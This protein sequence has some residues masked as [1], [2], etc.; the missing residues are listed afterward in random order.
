MKPK[1]NFRL[2][3]VILVLVIL[4]GFLVYENYTL[5][6]ED[7]KDDILNRLSKF[8][9]VKPYVDY[10]ASVTKLTQ[11]EINELAKKQPAIY[12]NLSGTELYKVQYSSET[13]GLLVIFDAKMNKIER[14]FRV[15]SMQLG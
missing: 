2:Y 3:L 14:I 4:I 11:S 6:K 12:A 13:D 7:I 10:E 8:E 15:T 5:T 9:D 1:S